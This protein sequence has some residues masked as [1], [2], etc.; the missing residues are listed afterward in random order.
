MKSVVPRSR[1]V[2]CSF[3]A[4]F[5]SA[6]LPHNLHAQS[7][8]QPPPVS[9]SPGNLAFG[10]PTGSTTSAPE[11]ATVSITATSSSPISFGTASV[12]Q[13]GSVNYS[14]DFAVS[15]SSCNGQTYTSAATCQLAV[16]FT[17]STS[18]GTLESATLTIPNNAGNL[19]V[20]LT[21]AYGAIQLWTSTTVQP[22]LASAS[23]TNV[24]TI[25]S[26]NLN[27]SC[28][29]SPV[30]TLSGTPDGKGNVMVDN[31]ITL[32]I[33][34]TPVATGLSSNGYSSVYPDQDGYS[35]AP[36]AYPPGNVCQGSDAYPDTQGNTYPEC[37]SAA[38]RSYVDSATPSPLL[39]V[40]T[41]SIAN[42]NAI[43]P[44]VN[45][46][47]A[48]GVAPLGT[49]GGSGNDLGTN[50][51][52]PYLAAKGGTTVPATFEAVDA[53][54]YFETSTVFLVTNCSLA[55]VAPG[56]SVTGNPISPTDSSTQTQTASFDSSP[57]TNISVTTSVAVAAQNG[58][59][60]PTVTPTFTDIGIPQ[61]LFYQL[62]GGTSAAP[63]VC[64]RLSGELDIYGQPMCKGI[65]V[66]CYAP[67][68]DTS[69]P[70]PG[71][72]TGN[73]CNPSTT[74]L[75]YIYNVV[76]F[77]SPDGPTN[78]YNYLYGPVP[79]GSATAADACSNVVPGGSCANGTG[80]GLL[81]GGDNWL[82]TDCVTAQTCPASGPNTKTPPTDTIYAQ[83]NCA[84][85]GALTGDLCPL[86]VLTQFFGAADA[87][88]GGTAPVVNSIY[89]PVVNMP[90]PPPPTVTLA[91]SNGWVNTQ[92]PNVTFIANPASY[93]TTTPS[94]TIPQNNNFT[95]AP[96]Y[97]V[98]Y[99]I[100]SYTS[101]LPDTTYPVPGDNT[102]YNSTSG[103][104]G[105]VSP[106][107][108]SLTTAS[109]TTA[110]TSIAAGS[111]GLFNLHYFT[112]DCALTEG[113]IFNPQ[114]SALTTATANWAS[115]PYTTFGVDS[116]TPAVGTCTLVT[117]PNSNNWYL[118]NPS[119]SCPVSETVNPGVSGSGFPPVVNTI[120]NVNQGG[121]SETVLLTTDVT[122]GYNKTA[123][124]TPS[125]TCN[126]AGT[127][128][129]VTYS[130][131]VQVDLAG[132]PTVTTLTLS[133]PGP[134]YVNGPTVTVVLSCSDGAGPG[135][136]SCAGTQSNGTN[137]MN[138]TPIP[139]VAGTYTITATAVDASGQ[140][141]QPATL[142][143]TVSAA[144]SADV[145]ILALPFTDRIDQN[146]TGHYYA[147]V[148]DLSANTAN[149]VTITSVFT[150]PNGVLN[151][152]ISAVYA[153]VSCSSTGCTIPA[154]G[155]SCSVNASVGATTTTETVSCP[156][157]Q[158]VS[159]TKGT[160]IVLNVSIP[161]A[162]TAPV[163]A[164]FT[165]VTTVTSDDD[166][167]LKN[168]TVT[169]SYSV[170]K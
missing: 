50:F 143:Y 115:F 162:S 150:V 82:A 148:I 86:S 118:A 33:N 105:F 8:S 41:D 34:G 44:P 89:V 23:F 69:A 30:A 122:S 111:D 56:G 114:G 129:P 100:T 160:G 64:M 135:I 169:E 121:A 146:T 6:V 88:G 39:G 7:G 10:V 14:G 156:V 61:S 154:S 67:P 106:L 40:N 126:L 140:Q 151:G 149:N 74:T 95:A 2:V 134:Y 110:P 131:T 125:S 155:T 83:A 24:Y 158:L 93:P 130:G 165:S 78:G 28:P 142:T 128:V 51:F 57:G 25:A 117:S 47:T 141:S 132:P 27:L 38:Y 94:S 108:G 42:S 46:N 58:D 84:L 124:F 4:V 81:M 12:S 133:A 168:N 119:V 97:A 136:T 35:S 167:N 5:V 123:A 170:L 161:V 113:L 147:G 1:L 164:T 70:N 66:Q 20:A 77:A 80:P 157:G 13:S 144:P 166:P 26:A 52:A 31:Y 49:L 127:C 22:S 79:A 96:A 68:T 90:V 65:W 159:I 29:S 112:T 45:N 137:V 101:S 92:S 32:A 71:E 3:L 163:N 103:S 73:N 19:T 9:V 16:T 11:T 63:A 85:T 60:V 76:Q 99:G 48:G 138:G 43:I 91:N 153:R 75:R 36:A 18:A 98:T 120:G 72:T 109:F 17:P 152:N 87:K 116:Q 55:G 107:C 104:T 15:G 62:V 59:S 102:L 53:G 145:A 37:F 54:G 21:G 139:N